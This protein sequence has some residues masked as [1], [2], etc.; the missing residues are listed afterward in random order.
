MRIITTLTIAGCLWRDNKLISLTDYNLIVRMSGGGNGRNAAV[1]SAANEVAVSVGAAEHLKQVGTLLFVVNISWF[2]LSH[3]LMLAR[4]AAASGF[5]VHVASNVED[6]SDI[7]QIEQGGIKFHR[8]DVARSGINP[9]SELKTLRSLSR[10]MRVIH[11]DVVH[12]VSAKAIIYGTQAARAHGIRGIVNAISGLGYVYSPG[13]G[14]RLLRE[15]LNRGY[16]R[17]FRPENVRIIVQNDD[18]RTQVL[19]LCPTAGDRI[20]LIVGSGVNLTEFAWSPEPGGIPAV[21][22][23]ARLLREKGIF[24]FAAAAAEL[25]RNGPAARFFVA[26]KLDRGNPGALTEIEMMNLCATSGVEW[27]GECKDMPRRF[28]E[29]NIVCLP[30]YREGAPKVLLEAGAAGRACV[31]TDSPGCRDVVSDGQT[32]VLVPPRDSRSL[33]AALR[34]LIENP[35]LRRRMGTEARNRAEQEFGVEKVVQSHLD[36]YRELIGSG[37]NRG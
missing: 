17:A 21:L 16:R 27:L 37:G 8:I 30:S 35:E 20:R 34:R 19:S 29:A 18:D 13:P 5:A 26:G 36:L 22:F 31:T 32:G 23:P 9:L 12:N 24:E 15:L 10:I 6:E 11:P 2:F 28:R 25:R 4:A 14:R 7:A 1:A 3:R 33:A